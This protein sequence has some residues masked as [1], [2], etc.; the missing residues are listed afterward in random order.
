M[1]FRLSLLVSVGL[2]AVLA[3]CGDDG[4]TPSPAADAGSDASAP[5]AS[6]STS[7]SASVTVNPT[8]TAAPSGST[9]TDAAVPD[10]TVP[11]GGGEGDGGVTDGGGLGPD[12][13]VPGFSISSPNFDDGDAL[14]DEYTCE[15]KPFGEGYSPNLVWEGAPEG[16]LSYGIIFRDIDVL[17]GDPAFTFR[18]YHWSAWNIP[19]SVTEIPEH[20]SAEEAPPALSG[21][22]QYRGGPPHEAGPEFF[23]PCPSWN[24]FC[25]DA[26]RVTDHYE[27]VLYAF[28]IE[29]QVPPDMP[30]PGPGVNY[31]MNLEAYFEANAVAKTVLRAT[32][33]AAPTEFANC[34]P[35][36][37]AD[38]GVDAGGADGGLSDGG[39]D[40]AVSDA[41]VS[42]AG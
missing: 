9:P 37:P 10:A 3:A 25:S 23:G 33:D 2:G 17:N 16:T 40:A 24:T 5:S 22:K 39:A 13:S 29:E 1:K 8:A 34:P 35:P 20:M 42:D 31:G 19:A 28:D 27:I 4:G 18:A 11:D 38:G 30:T 15:G 6:L 36:P 26:P 7:P 14:P 21:G 41:E 32:S 12:A